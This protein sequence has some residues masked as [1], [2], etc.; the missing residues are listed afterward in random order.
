MSCI[1]KILELK[2]NKEVL[3]VPNENLEVG[4]L[5]LL[6]EDG[7]NYKGY[8]YLITF[9]GLGFRCGYVALPSSHPINNDYQECGYP[10]FE[11]HGGITFFDENHLSEKFFG[12]DACHDKWLGFD[13]GHGYDLND[14]ETAKKYFADNTKIY[15]FTANFN[16]ITENFKKI[17]E[18]DDIKIRTKE[19]VIAEC[20]S[21][22]EQLI[23]KE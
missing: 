5:C 8:D 4:S 20:K 23:A 15:E 7:G 9:T 14:W 3:P 6:V 17:E 21:L 22:I 10:D 1:P 12:E 13:C 11:V 19:Y 18:Y 16:K 2:G